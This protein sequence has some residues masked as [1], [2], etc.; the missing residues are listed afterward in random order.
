M[1]LLKFKGLIVKEI[2][3]R[4][5]NLEI[6][7]GTSNNPDKIKINYTH[8]QS[9]KGSNWGDFK[10]PHVPEYKVTPSHK[11]NVKAATLS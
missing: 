5:F 2:Y 1:F 3:C 4:E 9:H 8:I 11:H 10:E 7:P 6:S